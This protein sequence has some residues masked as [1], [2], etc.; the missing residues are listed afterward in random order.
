MTR[1]PSVF[2]VDH[3]VDEAARDKRVLDE[4]ATLQDVVKAMR[5]AP[6]WWVKPIYKEP[7]SVSGEIPWR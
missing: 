2:C 1:D 7:A 3:M 4:T 5:A 6:G